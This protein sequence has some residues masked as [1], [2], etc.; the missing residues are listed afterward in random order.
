MRLEAKTEMCAPYGTEVQ[1][2]GSQVASIRLMVRD[3]QIRTKNKEQCFELKHCECN[4]RNMS[5]IDSRFACPLRSIETQME[6]L[7][8]KNSVFV[9]QGEL[10]ASGLDHPTR[11]VDF[12]HCAMCWVE[13]YDVL[14]F[15]I[16]LLLV[17][18]KRVLSSI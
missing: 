7:I 2:H 6:V 8:W 11:R 4:N 16:L 5:P 12:M 18:I 3:S 15:I 10:V 1:V 9:L 14:C 17:I 13:I